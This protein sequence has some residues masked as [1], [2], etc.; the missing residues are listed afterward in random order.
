MTPSPQVSAWFTKDTS[1]MITAGLVAAYGFNEGTGTTVADV[2]G[3]NNNGTISGATRTTAGKFGS[4]LVFNGTN[5]LVSIPNSASLQLTTAMTLEAWVNPSVVNSAWRDV[6]YKGNDNYYLEA[7]SPNGGRPGAGGTF[8]GTEVFGTAILATNTWTHLTTTYDGATL[9]L[10]VNGVEIS[11]LARTGAIATSTNPLQIGGDS[12]YGQLFQGMIDEVR[13]YNRALTQ[14]E[15]QQD[16][17]TAIGGGE[18]TPS[19]SPTLNFSLS[20][21]GDKSV[22]Q[23]QSVTNTITTTLSSGTSQAVVFSASGLPTGATASFSS[24]SCSPTC[25]S[26]VDHQHDRLDSCGKLYHHSHGDRRRRNQDY[27]L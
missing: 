11:S 1:P 20:N 27:E 9:R 23:G 24:A 25:S 8:S 12:I 19:A 3:N 22:T 21:G 15:I 6:I 17:I 2:S 13:V 7:M 26:T 5:G 18:S 14:T 16:M 4:A 10:Y